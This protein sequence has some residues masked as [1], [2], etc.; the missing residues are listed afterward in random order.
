[1][2]RSYEIAPQKAP[3]STKKY[4]PL[5]HS[6]VMVEWA[7]LPL[8]GGGWEGDGVRKKATLS[9]FRPHPHPNPPL[10]GEGILQQLK[11]V[12]RHHYCPVKFMRDQRK[13]PIYAAFR[14]F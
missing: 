7:L 6:Q 4:M 10:E 5:N 13:A 8:Q 14:A 1:M 12:H 3:I 9:A 2:A 11:I